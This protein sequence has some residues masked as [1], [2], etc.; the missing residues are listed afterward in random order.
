VDRRHD[1]RTHLWTVIKG[2]R[3][4]NLNFFYQK[5][6]QGKCRILATF[7]RAE[8]VRVEEERRSYE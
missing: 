8:D 4:L 2:G 5:E 3:F 7:T 6:K 1:L